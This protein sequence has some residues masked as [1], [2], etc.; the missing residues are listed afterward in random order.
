MKNIKCFGTEREAEK[1]KNK[2]KKY[3]T[4]K[5]HKWTVQGNCLVKIRRKN[6]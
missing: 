4:T 1:N 3:K 5:N 6:K 2:Y